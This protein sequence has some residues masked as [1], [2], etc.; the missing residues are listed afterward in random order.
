MYYHI[1][2]TIILRMIYNNAIV[3]IELFYDDDK[4]QNLGL[5]QN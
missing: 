2:S 3:E 4:N 5:G 1:D